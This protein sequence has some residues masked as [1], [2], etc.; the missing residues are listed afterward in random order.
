MTISI[1]DLQ[2]TAESHTL[3]R[4]RTF[5]VTRPTLHTIAEILSSLLAEHATGK[6]SINLSGGTLQNINFEERTKIKLT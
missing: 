1:T 4:E 5:F 2:S 6:I 3:I